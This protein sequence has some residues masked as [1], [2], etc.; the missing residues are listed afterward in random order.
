MMKANLFA[1]AT[2][3]GFSLAS[4]VSPFAAD[5]VA[6]VIGNNAYQHSEPLRTAVSDATAVAASLR[7]L[8][9]QVIF[10][11]D[12]GVETLLESLSTLAEKSRGAE[13]AVVYFAGHG[14]ESAG[15]NYLLPV[16]AVLE[17]EVQLR[18]QAVSLDTVLSELKQ[19]NVPARMVILDCCRDNPLEGR[20]W[21]ATRSAG[22][23]LAALAQDTLAE[24]TLVVYAASP[25][26]PALDLVEK[27]DTHSPFTT[28]LLEQLAKPDVHSFEMFGMVEDAV[29]QH[30][31]G[32]QAPRIFYNGSTQPFRNFRFATA[33]QKT[34]APSAPP[35]VRMEAPGS[36]QASYR[37]LQQL[38]GKKVVVDV[39]KLS[40]DRL[41][42]LP[43]G[44]H[45][46]KEYYT[47][48][49]EF[50]KVELKDNGIEVTQRL[51][52]DLK[53][54]NGHTNSEGKN[55]MQITG[56][57]TY[58]IQPRDLTGL[59]TSSEAIS[60]SDRTS[61]SNGGWCSLEVIKQRK[62]MQTDSAKDLKQREEDIES[63]YEKVRQLT[64]RPNDADLFI[65]L[66][67]FTLV[68]QEGPVI[69]PSRIII[70]D[71][72]FIFNAIQMGGGF[73]VSRSE[74]RILGWIGGIISGGY[75]KDSGTVLSME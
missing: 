10:I 21:R 45:R 69:T 54:A 73:L 44:R 16:D 71:D 39:K 61:E 67:D 63:L 30:T 24:A 55:Q 26:K 64:P 74:K 50:L 62:P 52:D 14:I 19:M 46:D 33:P 9:F 29:I 43:Q 1:I 27:G 38:E 68:S 3:I 57:W 32:R 75:L 5:R 8:G 35:A 18:T 48:T 12:A 36:L 23:G 17:R 13:A 2:F 66:P 11:Q 47:K 58:L 59:F 41:N 34:P 28:A 60:K 51:N 70:H 72:R 22:H 49:T 7:G 25:G 6:L 42:V 53:F 56:V 4:E 37:Q 15:V 31:G 20:S 40:K 65:Y